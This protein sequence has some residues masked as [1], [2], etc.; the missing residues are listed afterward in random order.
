MVKIKIKNKLEGNFFYSMVKLKR[1][2][3]FIKKN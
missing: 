3:N 2:N 1:K